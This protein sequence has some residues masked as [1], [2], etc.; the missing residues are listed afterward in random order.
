MDFEH[1]DQLTQST[2][3]SM[4]DAKGTTKRTWLPAEGRRRLSVHGKGK[5][6]DQMI[7]RSSPA[8]TGGSEPRTSSGGLVTQ[9]AA[10][11]GDCSQLISPNTPLECGHEFSD[12]TLSGQSP[13]AASPAASQEVTS[14]PSLL[15]S[16]SPTPRAWQPLG[17][18]ITITDMSSSE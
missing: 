9:G 2:Q 1:F 4:P 5:N 16:K 6:V 18:N 11:K 7:T 13:S 8:L 10:G 12:S 14:K 17:A 3:Q 15:P